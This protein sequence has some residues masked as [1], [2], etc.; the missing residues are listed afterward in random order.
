MNPQTFQDA[1]N[2]YREQGAP[3]NQQ[4]LAALLREVQEADGGVLRFERLE[5]IAEAYQLPLSLLQ[6]LIRRISALRTEAAPH[7]LEMCRTCPKNRELAA[8]VRREYGAESGCISQKGGFVFERVNC[9]KNCKAGPSIRWDGVL[10]PR[11][12]EPLLRSLI[13]SKNNSR[14]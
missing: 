13:E 10:Y 7:R 3:G 2:H 4:L 11:A 8:F 6:A 9:M 12:D 1:L 14:R 5:A